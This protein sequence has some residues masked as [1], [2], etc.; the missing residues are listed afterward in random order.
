M[1]KRAIKNKV[2]GFCLEYTRDDALK[3]TIKT[4]CK[5]NKASYYISGD[6]DL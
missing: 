5:D 2:E 3:K 1:I 6:V 4:W